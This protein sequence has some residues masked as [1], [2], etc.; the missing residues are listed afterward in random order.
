MS[1]LTLQTL[2]DKGACPEQVKKFRRK[3]GKQVN[4]TVKLCQSVAKDFDWGWA[5][6][7]L[8]PAPIWAEYNRQHAPLYAEYQRQHAPIRAEYARQ[9]AL[10]WAE[11]ERQRARLF[12]LAYNGRVST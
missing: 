5:A 12:A 2:I 1:I 6:R 9:R 4:V 11:Y 7:N 3:F 10:I 8:L